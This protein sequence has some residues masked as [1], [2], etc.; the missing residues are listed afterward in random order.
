MPIRS[1]AIQLTLA[2][3]LTSVHRAVAQES[4]LTLQ[5]DSATS[6]YVTV[7]DSPSLRP[8]TFTIECWVRPD[9]LGFGR[10]DDTFGAALITKPQQGASGTYIMSWYLGW[11]PVT[12]TFAGSVAHTIPGS[13]TS[14]IGQV[15]TPPGAT[16]HVAL[17]F[18]G[19][20]LSLYIN[21]ALDRQVAAINANVAYT[22]ADVLI[23]AAN[24]CCNYLRRYDGAIDEVRIWDHALAG[25]TLASGAFCAF[26]SGPPAGLL[27]RWQFNGGSFADASLNGNHG[28]PVGAGVGFG[29]PVVVPASGCGTI[30]VRYCSPAPTN[31]TGQ[32]SAM[33]AYGSTLVGDDAL[34]LIAE[35]LPANAF[36]Y[37]L[38]SR[39]QGFV[40]HPGGS[41]GNLC[42]GGA[43]GRF[44]G[45][46]QV[47]NAGATGTFSLRPHVTALPTPTGLR[48]A[49]AGE[50]WNFQAWHRDSVGGVSTSNLTDAIA[51]TYQ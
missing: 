1:F 36:G 28:T 31:S 12:R 33:H 20:H 3:G 23:G 13:G 30:G 7:P 10:T 14:V 22:S 51:L 39:T 5:N 9:G 11:A 47:R 15:T 19:A 8:Q 40:L 42:L 17:T 49:V 27:A 44:V 4:A 41:Q 6:A 16:A 26:A 18:D 32:S 45:P 24:F 2:C 50:T 38:T 29:A 43:I 46:G 21:G 37:F 34:I 48:A 25:P 35:L